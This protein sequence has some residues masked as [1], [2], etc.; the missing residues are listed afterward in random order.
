MTK[1]KVVAVVGAQFG[2]EGKGAIVGHIAD[3][4]DVHVRV[5]GPNA[6]H[7]FYHLGRPWVMQS[8]PCGWKNPKAKLVIGAGATVDPT[9]LL[10]EIQMVA[11]V[12][13]TIHSRVFVDPNA[14][15]LLPEHYESEGG[16]H[17]SGHQK[18]GSTGKGVGACREARM[19]RG[20]SGLPF[21]LAKDYDILKP[22]LT[23]T[24]SLLATEIHDGKHILLEGT[25]GSGLS[26]VHG[27][28]PFCT[29][30]D[31]N[32]G[33]LAVDAGIPPQFVTDVILV[34]RTMPIRVAGNSGPLKNETTWE[35]ISAR[36]GKEVTEK[37]T[38]TKKTRRIG[39]WDD[40]LFARTCM[41][42]G[43]TGV[44]ITF[45]DYINPADFGVTKWE[46]LSQESK[47]FVKKVSN[48]HQV[49]VV[50]VTTGP[51]A[52][53]YIDLDVDLW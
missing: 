32:A 20:V 25:Q 15:V 52:E 38:V 39:E 3:N 22:Y 45:L 24:V 10:A 17:G 30:A 33:Q 28:W 9:N 34:A 46:D 5:G 43:P 23:D 53:H 48:D 12:D 6:G 37:T 42:N 47:D 41:L 11:E 27:P 16:V 21:S 40:E 4:F 19:N 18:I 51:L 44:A 2:S 13:P 36:L 29:S 35:A 1:G 50:A 31:T 49:R 14:S 26:L 7:T 8:V